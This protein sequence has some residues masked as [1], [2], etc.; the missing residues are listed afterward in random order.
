M[1]SISRLTSTC[2]LKSLE[3]Q[4]V[5]TPFYDVQAYPYTP[6]GVDP[7]F[8]VV[9]DLEVGHPLRIPRNPPADYVQTIICRPLKERN[10]GVEVIRWFRD[11]DVHE[12]SPHYRG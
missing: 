8:A 9:G 6:P 10:H 3:Q 11:E 2:A 1:P 5:D 12:M 7:V 4:T